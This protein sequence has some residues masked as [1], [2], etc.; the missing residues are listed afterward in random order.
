MKRIARVAIDSP[1]PSLDRLF[2]YQVPDAFV[3]EV[4]I[5]CRVRVSFGRSKKL[6]DAFVVDLVEK[7]EFE[8]KLATIGELVSTFPVLQPNIYELIRR[9]ADRQATAVADLFSAAIPTR[10]VAVE[11]KFV[12]ENHGLQERRR[13]DDIT[14]SARLASPTSVMTEVGID[15]AEWIAIVLESAKGVLAAGQSCIVIVPDF[16]DQ[17]AFREALNQSEF[18]NC[19]IDYSSTQTGSQR[20]SSFLSCFTEGAHLV[21]GSR[22]AIFAPLQN[23]GLIAVFDDGDRNLQDLQSPYAHARDVALLRQDTD[24]CSL[25]FVSHSRS[26]EV[27]RLVDLGFLVEATTALQ[28]PSIAFD[29]GQDRISSLAYNLISEASKTGPV[30]VQVAAKGTARTAYCQACNSRALCNFCNGPIWIDAN[31][32]PRCR[33]CNAQNLSYKCNTCSDSQLRQG[34][35]GITRTI[36][37]FGK[38]FAGVQ[39]IEAS[40]EKIVERV[41]KSPK[42]VFATPGAEPTAEGGYAA[43]VLLDAPSALSKD[44]LRAREDAVRNWSNAIAKAKPGGRSVIVGVPHD[45]GQ[46]FALWKQIELAREELAS[47]KELNF[48]P[49]L[50][51]G[52]IEGTADLLA[53]IAIEIK[54]DD[55][56]VLG[57]IQV[58][59]KSGNL[60][61]RI[62]MKYS[63]GGARLLADRL[64]AAQLKFAGQTTKTN[65]LGRTSRAIRIRMDDPEVI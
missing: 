40:G 14:R 37:E 18:A 47:R 6:L 54:S 8:G 53:Q 57:P 61:Q 46:K 55:V 50:R 59:D 33:W 36:A 56:Q 65:E 60:N 20:Y 15:V 21:L 38:A 28:L 62:V 19:L 25:M 49:H 34:P 10:S 7:S 43:V 31:G 52:S 39:L 22:G 30:L 48:P 44:S 51:L 24:Q 26:T 11:K 9:V 32:V 29:D 63:Y 17:L 23:L 5:G 64:K 1:L 12:A 3:N 41:S 13:S 2:D 42:I 27:Q 4:K 45:L 58:R 35:G 16:R